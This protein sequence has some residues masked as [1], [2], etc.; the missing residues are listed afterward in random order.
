VM[1]GVV[2]M[3][4]LAASVTP[5]GLAAHQVIG[6]P[7][8]AVVSAAAALAFFSVSN[9]GILAAS[10]YPLA[11]GRDQLLP[12]WFAKCNAKGTPVQAVLVTVGTIIAVIALLDPLSIA[13]LASTFMLLMFAILCLAVIVMRESHLD[14]YDPGYRVPWYPAL[15]IFGL[16]SPFALIAQMGT[17]PTLFGLG[18]VGAGIAWYL[19]Y[20]SPRVDRKGALYHV[21]ARLGEQRNEGLDVELRSIL[22]EKGLRDQDPI[23]E[24]I[25]GA[26]VLDV[27][28]RETFEA[29]VQHAAN[30]LAKVTGHP[31][32][33]F[34]QGFTEGTLMGATPVAKGV[35][36]P[37]MRLEGLERP[38][39]VL[40]RCRQALHI[41]AGNVFGKTSLTEGVHAIFFLVSPEEDPGQHLRLLAHLATCI[42]KPKFMPT[43]LGAKTEV[44]LREVFLRNE[45]YISVELDPASPASSWIGQLVRNLDLPEGCLIAAVQR[46]NHTMVPRGGTQLAEGDRLLIIGDPEPIANLYAIHG[47]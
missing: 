8:M 38:E 11:M 25:L 29:L 30:R 24:L 9:A 39:M 13:K 22:K 27:A 42:D 2:P 14:S 44:E 18:L 40:V 31:A 33:V 16:L 41:L 19:T 7:G 6:A 47:N 10:R 21:F 3:D 43:W 34:V 28:G 4:Q 23:N 17:A 36:L 26:S 35:A 46:G 20:A 12:P 5:M 32:E 15:P 45:R 37:H 1:V